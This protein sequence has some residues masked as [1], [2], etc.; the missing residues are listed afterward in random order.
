L[1]RKG[2]AALTK[3]AHGMDLIKSL[4]K[5][6]LRFL[7]LHGVFAINDPEIILSLVGRHRELEP[8]PVYL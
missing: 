5:S 6:F 1:G 3:V 2:K 7:R 8:L 4:K